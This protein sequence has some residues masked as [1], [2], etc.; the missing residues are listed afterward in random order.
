M[1]SLPRR[2]PRRAGFSLVDV[3]VA[4]A[5]LAIAMGTLI[6][7]VFYALRLEEANEETA[8]ASQLAR[9]LLERIDTLPF[10][11]IY[12]AYNLNPADDPDPGVDHLALLHGDDPLQVLGR[13]GGAAISVVFP[14]DE[15]KELRED[16]DN[17]ALGLPRDLNGDGAVDK[18]DHSGDYTLLP[19]TL[20]LAWD[21][22]AGPRTLELSTLLRS[23]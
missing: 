14:G 6:G 22:A 4:I 16:V 2:V 21:G 7:T 17:P 9:T 23:R 3:C 10:E 5:I 15:G 8:A 13:K 11:Q 1:K 20:R 12:S 18:Q 19:V